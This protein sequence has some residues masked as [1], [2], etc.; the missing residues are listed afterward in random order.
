MDLIVITLCWSFSYK[1]RLGSFD[2]NI[3]L[4]NRFLLI[5]IS[6]M[7]AVYVLEAADY[8]IKKSPLRQ[9][10]KYLS[11]C[12]L[13][14][15]FISSVFYLN[16]LA[17]TRGGQDLL[18]RGVVLPAFIGTAIV[19]GLIRYLLF[20]KMKETHSI[21]NWLVI[22]SLDEAVGYRFWGALCRH[23]PGENVHYWEPSSGR[24]EVK[25]DEKVESLPNVTMC[26]L[27]E[28]QWASIILLD[29]FSFTDSQIESLMHARLAGIPIQTISDFYEDV[30][31]K[32]PVL[33]LN[34][35]WFAITGGFGLLHEP[36]HRKVK[37]LC[38]LG[39][40]ILILALTIPMILLAAMW[41][42]IVG[43][44]GAV[45]YKQNRT[46][47]YGIPFTINKLRTMY[48]NSEINGAQ[49]ATLDDKRIIL[50]GNILRKFRIDELPQLW[51]IIIGDMSFIGPRPERPEIIV[52]LEKK[53]PFY[54][55]RHL[56]KPGLT[57]WAQ[58]SFPYGASF[59]DSREK[60]EYDLYYIKHQTIWLDFTIILMT[61]R[62]ILRGFG[63]R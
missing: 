17:W 4:S 38:D 12:T 49:W 15:I 1:L 32:V 43:G 52:D 39:L 36:I 6:F 5:V 8:D 48:A 35:R 9:S 19:G 51:N 44:R 16:A 41:I 27:L 55:L 7:L 29:D 20:N 45:I 13:A 25:I 2:Q 56:I 62:V 61:M 63:G 60:L 21:R 14:T 24:H 42:K 59:E 26:Q 46:G 3:Y 54:S 33:H 28:K 10:I 50:F 53:I 23:V 30:W 37:R 11:A 58:V 18:G 31:N 34:N 40:A 47:H 57:G 22:G